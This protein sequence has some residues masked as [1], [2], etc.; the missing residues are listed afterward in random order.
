MGL[1]SQEDKG[2]LLAVNTA[3]PCAIAAVL[4]FI[5]GNFYAQ[6]KKEMELEKEDAMTKASQFKFTK[7]D[8]DSVMSYGHFE[9]NQVTKDYRF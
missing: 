1:E 9:Y 4:F 3:V 6:H 7:E 8:G 2:K 5:S